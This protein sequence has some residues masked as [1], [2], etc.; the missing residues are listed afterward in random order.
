LGIERLD[1]ADDPAPPADVGPSKDADRSGEVPSSSDIGRAEGQTPDSSPRES[2]E[3]ATDEQAEP[4]TRDEYADHLAPPNSS[5]IEEDSTQPEKQS[6]SPDEFRAA[7]PHGHGYPETSHSTAEPD[8]EHGFE[9]QAHRNDPPASSD[10]LDRPGV[11]IEEAAELSHEDTDPVVERETQRQ[12]AETNSGLDTDRE[13]DDDLGHTPD[14]P[15]EPPAVDGA[16]DLPSDPPPSQETD[17]GET[18]KPELTP[19]PEPNEESPTDELV[20]RDGSDQDTLEIDEKTRPL[21][22]KEWA[23]HL[24]E[25]RQILDQARA[26]GLESHL[27]Y[28]IDPDHQSW[29]K[30]RRDLHASIINDLYSSARDVPNMG[31]AIVAGGLGGAGKTTV[32]TERA[33]IDLSQY[34]VINPDNLKVEMARR[35]MTP[36]IDR[37]SP[38][39]ASDLV[40]EESSYLARQLAL[41]A[42]ADRKNVIW[43]ITMSDE[44]RIA[45]RLNELRNAG[46]V[47]VD[48]IFVDIPVETSI[49]RTEF[50]HREGHEK[51]LAGDGLGGRYVP[52]KVI[53]SQEDPEWG[54]HNR[55]TFD[56]MKG[57]FNN[58]SIYDNS[59]ERRPARVI[60]SSIEN[61]LNEHRGKEDRI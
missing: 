61:G 5:P 20:A 44:K 2:P 18:L 47:R 51:F 16:E 29:I 25:V 46:Y 37:L 11:P 42:Y 28:T 3:N 35:G 45:M 9:E 41:R 56:R 33:D 12:D 52:P 10:E 8:E 57:R 50:R 38:M 49:T 43:D 54:S 40:H 26:N 1:D 55:R 32:L 23:E 17:G 4:R 34:L 48:G 14:D 60:E 19:S 59:A 27:V 36:A 13:R 7:V 31:Q 39:E 58:W 21:T 53:R 22:D 24:A 30:D 15:H 6:Q